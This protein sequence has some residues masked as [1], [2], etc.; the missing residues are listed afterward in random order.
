MEERRV[1]DIVFARASGE[2]RPDDLPPPAKRQIQLSPNI[3]LGRH[4]NELWEAV[5]KACIPPGYN[6]EPV[7]WLVQLYA[8]WNTSPAKPAEC[9]WDPDQ[10]LAATVALSRLVHPN[11]IGFK[12][13]ARITLSSDDQ[14]VQIVPGPVS[15][16]LAHAF[17]IP[18]SYDW[19]NDDDASAL[20]RLCESFVRCSSVLPPRLK[21]A[22][23]NCEYAAAL[24]W[25]DLRWGVVA[26]ALESLVHTDR[27]HSTRQFVDRVAALAERLIVEFTKDD[28]RRAYGLRSSVAHGQGFQSLDDET[29]ALYR[30]M[31]T[32]LR[33]SIRQAIEDAAF[34]E[35]FMSDDTIRAEF[36][37]I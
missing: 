25:V 12:Y 29:V 10:S 34:R 19:L 27:Q 28:A 4:T 33:C 16:L 36:P 17:V 8:F 1:I 18:G 7:R 20:G 37:S 30:R 26:T 15:G 5:C 6:F 9:S 2:G 32:V 11:S 14:I 24:E 22:F 21:R 13:S 31:E 35:I 3:Y 23:W